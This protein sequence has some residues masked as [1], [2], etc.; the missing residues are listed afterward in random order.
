MNDNPGQKG[1]RMGTAQAVL[2]MAGVLFL[3][4]CVSLVKE[5]AGAVGGLEG[6][7]KGPYPEL[8]V[9]VRAACSCSRISLASLM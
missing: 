9:D 2:A 7:P 5:Q 3:G 4:S 6:V 1:I 8:C